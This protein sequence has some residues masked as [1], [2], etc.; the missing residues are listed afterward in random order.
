MNIKV[1][2]VVASYL[3]G[4]NL[5][6][7]EYAK[8]YGIAIWGW[9]E[10][11][12]DIV[13]KVMT[14]PVCLDCDGSFE[15]PE[16]ALNIQDF[17]IANNSDSGQSISSYDQTDDLS[18]CT[19]SI[20]PSPSNVRGDFK[21]D[22][23]ATSFYDRGSLGLGSY[24]TIG[25]YMVKMNERKIYVQDVCG[26]GDYLL[27]YLSYNNVEGQYEINELAQ[28]ALKM[29]IRWQLSL[30]DPRIGLGEKMNNERMYYNEKRK[31]KLRIKKITIQQLNKSARESEKMAVK[32]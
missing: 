28:A 9:R 14:I 27:K 3:D 19:P 8:T 29:Y 12:W 5:G 30:D 10:L 25:Y 20:K 7:S 4:K 2:E 6:A 1:S 15:I 24:E 18:R 26:G 22:G 13:G 31:A 17:G 32:S 21:G 11:N 23:V 16:D